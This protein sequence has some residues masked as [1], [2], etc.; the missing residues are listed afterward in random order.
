M[1]VCVSAAVPNVVDKNDAIFFPVA[2]ATMFQAL[3]F[4]LPA[5]LLHTFE[6]LRLRKTHEIYSR[7]SRAWT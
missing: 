5:Q 4:L 3:R 2:A 1:P 6:S 7:V